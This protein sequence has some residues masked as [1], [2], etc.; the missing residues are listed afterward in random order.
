M[1]KELATAAEIKA[2]KE[3]H[4][5]LTHI[6]I[7]LGDEDDV[8]GETADYII[9]RPSRKVLSAVGQYGSQGNLNKANEVLIKNCVLK[10]DMT[11]I[12]DEKDGRVFLAVL[13][14]IG[15]LNEEKAA[16]VK[17]L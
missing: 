16:V 17:K 1:G 14:E 7:P 8:N 15:K 3:K 13:K 11:H 5:G 12:E 6:S 10:G 2:L 4:S 9:C